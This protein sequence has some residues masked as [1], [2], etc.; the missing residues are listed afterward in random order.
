MKKKL[1]SIKYDLNYL[2]KQLNQ[3]NSF[4]DLYSLAK[5]NLHIIEELQVVLEENVPAWRDL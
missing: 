3:A 1:L 4:D 2:E 5:N